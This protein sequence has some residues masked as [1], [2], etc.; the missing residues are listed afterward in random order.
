MLVI[1]GKSNCGYCTK[2]KA[3]AEQYNIVHE[4]KNTD[5]FEQMQELFEKKSNVKTLPQI[6]WHDKYIGGYTEF[7]AEVENTMGNYGQG[8]F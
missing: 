2:A 5:Q 3:L 4:Y 8:T 6:W 7:A 1:Y